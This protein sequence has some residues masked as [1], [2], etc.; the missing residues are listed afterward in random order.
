MVQ[1]FIVDVFIII[2]NLN[3]RQKYYVDIVTEC[4]IGIFITLKIK[5][6]MLDSILYSMIVILIV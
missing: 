5:I 4:V 2:A 3:Y 6:V 1:K